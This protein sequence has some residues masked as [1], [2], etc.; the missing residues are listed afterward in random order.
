MIGKMIR[1]S[2]FKNIQITVWTLITLTTSAALVAM[3][4]TVS[5]DVGKKMSGALRKFGP[6][7]VA[8]ANSLKDGKPISL[9]NW[10]VLENI[11]KEKGLLMAEQYFDIMITQGEPVV[12]VMSDPKKLAEMTPYWAILGHRAMAEG[13]CLIGQRVADSLKL[14]AGMLMGVHPSDTT[15]ERNY[16]IAGILVSGDENED[17]IFIPID[18]LQP[19]K[20]RSIFAFISVPEGEEGIRQL[21]VQLNNE[22]SGITIKPIREILYGEETILK[23]IVLLF[24][25]SLAVVLTLTSLGVSSALLSRVV[26]RKKELALLR[27][28]GATQRSV[29][30]FLLFE[31]IAIG[32][33]ASIGG[34]LIGILISEIIVHQIFHVSVTPQMIVFPITLI[35]TTAVSLV[36]GGIGAVRALRMQPALAL[37]GE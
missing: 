7:A 34:F 32:I 25:I 17:R 24:S 1:G 16:R 21:N 8:S 3:F 4:T 11:V 18:S 2:L 9:A 10:E 37:K 29:V 6:N 12:A 26:Q 15:K 27:A 35:V 13:E 14:K 31:S 22:Y 5:F 33:T 28:I 20:Y 36:A 30:S 23:K 19:L